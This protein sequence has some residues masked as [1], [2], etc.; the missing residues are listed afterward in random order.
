MRNEPAA[1][2]AG[3]QERPVGEESGRTGRSAGGGNPQGRSLAPAGAGAELVVEATGP[4]ATVQDAGRPGYSDL[5]VGV[6]G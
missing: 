6:S 1:T 2:E 4:Q 5:G 3:A